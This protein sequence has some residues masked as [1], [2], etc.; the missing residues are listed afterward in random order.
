MACSPISTYAISEIEWQRDAHCYS[1]RPVSEWS[2]RSGNR[3]KESQMHTYTRTQN[4]NMYEQ[5]ILGHHARC[6]VL[7][8]VSFCTAWYWNARLCTQCFEIAVVCWNYGQRHS[9]F[10]NEASLRFPLKNVYTELFTTAVVRSARCRQDIKKN[11]NHLWLIHNRLRTCENVLPSRFFPQKQTHEIGETIKLCL[12]NLFLELFI[13]SLIDV[14][15]W[16]NLSF[17]IWKTYI[18]SNSMVWL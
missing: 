18:K 14:V 16:V 2:E 5:W 12:L 6:D 15:W 3:T 9:I 17:N 4:T 11:N 8:A 7:L 13:A 10:H 1:P